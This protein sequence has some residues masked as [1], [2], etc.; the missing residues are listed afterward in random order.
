MT[1]ETRSEPFVMAMNNFMTFSGRSDV[2]RLQ[3]ISC[4]PVM[5]FID[6]RKPLL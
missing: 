5:V 4:D 1:D 3:S 6:M 2:F